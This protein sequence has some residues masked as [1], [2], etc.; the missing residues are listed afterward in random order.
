MALGYIDKRKLENT[1][2]FS[3]Y[4]SLTIYVENEGYSPAAWG[5]RDE[6]IRGSAFTHKNYISM[7]VPM[8]LK[9]QYNFSGYID[10]SEITSCIYFFVDDRDAEEALLYWKLQLPDTF[11]LTQVDYLEVFN[12]FVVY[13][14]M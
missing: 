14:T 6:S 11:S 2:L 12:Y 13:K 5:S 8:F 4:E 9:N 10:S 1:L 7:T 3:K